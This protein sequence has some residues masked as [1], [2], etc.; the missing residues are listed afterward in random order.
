MK[1]SDD[2]YKR[3]VHVFDMINKA[4][5]DENNGKIGIVYSRQAVNEVFD[6]IPEYQDLFSINFDDKLVIPDDDTMYDFMMDVNQKGISHMFS[7]MVN[8]RNVEILVDI[9]GEVAYHVRDADDYSLNRESSLGHNQDDET[10][11]L[12]KALIIEWKTVHNIE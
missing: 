8:H 11:R 9:D 3:F 2:L 7:D 12:L 10:G 5:Q 1:I 4:E 6:E